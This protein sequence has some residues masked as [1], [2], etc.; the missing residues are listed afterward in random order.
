MPGVFGRLLL[1]L[2]IFCV[3]S[4][5]FS[6]FQPFTSKYLLCGPSLLWINVYSNKT[7]INY[8]IFSWYRYTADAIQVFGRSLKWLQESL[9]LLLS[10]NDQK[11]KTSKIE[12]KDITTRLGQ[13]F[14]SILYNMHPILHE[15]HF[16]GSYLISIN[17]IFIF[18]D[19][20]YKWYGLFFLVISGARMTSAPLKVVS[21]SCF[22]FIIRADPKSTIRISSFPLCFISISCDCKQAFFTLKLISKNFWIN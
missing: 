3:F 11:K 20:I 4:F 12:V 22:D 7:L 6:V 2:F 8:N 18:V 1:F 10:G 15:S 17:F 14:V 13:L 21:F 16:V 19:T 5:H 9:Y